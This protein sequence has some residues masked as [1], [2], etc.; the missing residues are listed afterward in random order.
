MDSED[1]NNDK[2]NNQKKLSKIIIDIENNIKEKNY[3]EGIK[4]LISVKELIN[5]IIEEIPLN[6]KNIK[7]IDKELINHF[8]FFK[9]MNSFIK[10]INILSQIK[11]IFNDILNIIFEEKNYPYITEPILFQELIVNCLNIIYLNSKS[12][13]IFFL[14]VKKVDNYIQYIIDNYPSYKDSILS[15]RN[16]FKEYHSEIY[17]NYKK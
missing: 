7:I 16:T 14:L 9:N 4:L 11:S 1:N 13:L 8:S 2:N 15:S 10:D 5:N 12:N 3:L 6:K 17:L